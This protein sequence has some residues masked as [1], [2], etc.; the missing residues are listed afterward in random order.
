MNNEFDLLLDEFGEWRKNKTRKHEP[1]PEEFWNKIRI[2]HQ[3]YPDKKLKSLLG[4]NSSSWKK[5]ICGDQSKK[6]NKSKFIQVNS[7]ASQK[8]FLKI[9]FINGPELVIFQ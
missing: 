8:E 9:K 4:I 7:V 2:I 6:N 1:I 5:K 3:K